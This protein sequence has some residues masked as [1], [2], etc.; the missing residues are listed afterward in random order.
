MALSSGNSDCQCRAGA[1]SGHEFGLSLQKKLQIATRWLAGV[2]P[3]A[4]R[5]LK[6]LIKVNANACFAWH[7]L[8]FHSSFVRRNLPGRNWRRLPP[9]TERRPVAGYSHSPLRHSAAATPSVSSWKRATMAFRFHVWRFS[10]VT[11]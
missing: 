9:V 6:D 1:L 4:I 5:P 11:Y 8:P 7:F 2:R 3:Q 10:R